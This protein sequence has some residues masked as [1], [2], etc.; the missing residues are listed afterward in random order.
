[1]ID[2]EEWGKEND[3]N[4]FGRHMTHSGTDG[5]VGLIWSLIWR[6]IIESACVHLHLC[7]RIVHLTGSDICGGSVRL[8]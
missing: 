7:D 5:A 1:M 8:S 6:K 4:M 2:V 3:G